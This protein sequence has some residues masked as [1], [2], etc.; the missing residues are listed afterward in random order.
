[1]STIIITIELV[2]AVRGIER[3][4]SL[5]SLLLQGLSVGVAAFRTSSAITVLVQHTGSLETLPFISPILWV[6]WISVTDHYLKAKLLDDGMPDVDS[7]LVIARTVLTVSMWVLSLWLCVG[8]GH[9]G[10]G[11]HQYNV[12]NV[13]VQC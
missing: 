6:D 5:T 3:Y 1:M 11:T 8:Y 10:Y 2:I 13:P 12:L 9:L 7:C 4:Y